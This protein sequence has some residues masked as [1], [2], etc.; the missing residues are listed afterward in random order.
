MIHHHSGVV[1]PHLVVTAALLGALV[2]CD[3]EI[4]TPVASD[5]IQ[6]MEADQ[7]IFGMKSFLTSRGIREGRVEADTA[8]MYADSA[9]A[10]LR[11]M[12]ITFYDELGRE[13]ATVTG[14]TGEWNQETNRMVARGDVVLMIASD[15]SRI[16]SQEIHY[17]PGLDKVWSDS[18]TVRTL[19]DGSV[20][21]GSA[22][23][24]DMSFENLR[25]QDMR[26]GARR[27]F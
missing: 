4:K 7:I 1:R 26:G 23:E 18:A 5:A 27:I 20:T 13:R 6:S 2:G 21:S 11:M 15:S 22:F 3:S 9:H 17:D 24:S 12:T 10:S 16:E 8:Y 19:A 14:R 25:I